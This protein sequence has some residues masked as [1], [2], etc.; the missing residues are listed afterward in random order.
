M[1]TAPAIFVLAASM[2]GMSGAVGAYGTLALA[3]AAARG[4][5]K[6][7]YWADVSDWVFEG[8]DTWIEIAALE[9]DD[10]FLSIT[11]LT[12]NA[13]AQGHPDDVD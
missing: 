8:N 10:A 13:P 11:Q 7:H 4:Y 2:E 1:T 5:R 12:L 6:D 9:G 3:Q